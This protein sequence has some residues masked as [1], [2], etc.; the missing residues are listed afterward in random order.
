MASGNR[1]YHSRF[2]LVALF[3]VVCSTLPAQQLPTPPNTR[4][5][6][7]SES[8]EPAPVKVVARRA[9][10]SA[11][12]AA[13]SVPPQL[14]RGHHAWARF[15]PGAWRRIKVTSE[16]FDANG[17]FLSR[18][19]TSQTESLVAVDDES[20]TLEL[21]SV[22]DVGGKRLRGAS[23]KTTYHLL[24]DAPANRVTTTR[25]DEANIS[26]AGAVIPVERWR[27]QIGTAE[28]EDRR[29]EILYYSPD[30]SPYLLRREAQSGDASES[31]QST[32]SVTRVDAPRLLNGGIVPTSHITTMTRNGGNQINEFE[33]QSDGVP[34]GLVSASSTERDASGRRV[35]WS[36]TELEDYGD[37][38]QPASQRRRWSPFR[39]HR[40]REN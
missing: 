4:S 33:V 25:L 39:R 36:T 3:S 34:G 40:D 24:C 19:E 21:V 15:Q 9:V 12:P 26:L 1:I 20:Y 38:P 18:S 35:R 10:T 16:S 37:A 11:P 22:V 2:R 31:L 23:Q 30:R 28:E 27:V 5:V 8:A 7:E 13:K 17:R 29:T 6:D 14:P 32:Q